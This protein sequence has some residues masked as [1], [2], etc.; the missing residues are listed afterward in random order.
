MF[1]IFVAAVVAGYASLFLFRD[2][3]SE[4]IRKWIY[5]VLIALG[6]AGGAYFANSGSNNESC[7]SYGTR[8]DDC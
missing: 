3:A 8:A 6:L 7:M 5:P 2:D 4:G 1:W